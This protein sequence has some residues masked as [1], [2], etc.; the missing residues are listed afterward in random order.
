MSAPTQRAGCLCL[1]LH[2]HLPYV[3][4]HGTWPHGLEW[5]VE[6]AAETY[7]P[8]VAT[9]RRLHADGVAFHANLSISP[10]LL[11][12]LADPAFQSELPEYL[13][14]KIVAAQ[15]DEAFFE[16]A[17]QPRYTA[18][19]RHWRAVFAE[20]LQQF[21]AMQCDLPAAFRALQQGGMLELM[22]SAATHGYIPLLGTAES[23]RAQL[24]TAIHSHTQHIGTAPRGVWLPE[25]GYRPAGAF[26]STLTHLA[27]QRAGTETSLAAA[28]LAYTIVDA[29]LIEDAADMD[30]NAVHAVA[31]NSLYRPYFIAD[32]QVAVFARDPR[33]ATQ[34]WN[35]QGGYPGD[36]EYLDF[37]KKRWPGGHRYWRVTGAGL[38]MNDKDIY[39]HAAAEERT[40]EHAR[41]FVALV[42]DTLTASQQSSPILCAPF[43]LELFGHWWHEGMAFLEH[44]AR[45]AAAAGVTMTS[46]SAYLQQHPP[47]RHIRLC[48]GSWGT[49]GDHSVWLNH[50]TT[51]LYRRLYA[52]EQTVR[53]ICSANTWQRN[54]TATR[55]AQQ[56]CRELLLMESSDWP[57]LITTGAARD[58]AQAR[59]WGH[60]LTLQALLQVWQQYLADGTLRDDSA[61]TLTEAEMCDALFPNIDP[62]LWSTATTTLTPQPVAAP[63]HD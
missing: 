45:A 19:A 15:E 50:D 30:G 18:L 11:E 3:L 51:E 17:Q 10:V 36:F 41:H 49:N 21:Q 1:T 26:T 39:H 60:A 55:I 43:D 44:V 6:A 2:A 24:S 13:R 29:P 9:V 48:E 47:T 8:L 5:L 28:N 53:E 61:A 42:A 22:T 12:Q 35:S 25:C 32:S 38:G 58:Y 4:H 14:R 56:L 40:R 23:V 16:Q 37:H 46:A 54:A 31:A 63:M 59:F 20:T 62:A 34:V 33:T 52:A 27:A 57:T 7:L